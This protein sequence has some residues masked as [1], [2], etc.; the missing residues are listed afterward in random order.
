MQRRGWLGLGRR[1]FLKAQ[2]RVQELRGRA[3]A[4]RDARASMLPLDRVHR[5]LELL[6]AAI[7]G[8]SIPI[9][10]LEHKWTGPNGREF[11]RRVFRM[12]API[13]SVDGDAIYLPR[14]LA[15]QDDVAALTRY[16]L[17]ALEQ[18]E[19][20]IRGTTE[21]T[22]PTDQLERD[23]YLLR[24]GAAIDAHIA[25]HHHGV[26]ELLHSE[27]GKALARR[28][29][30]SGMTIAE[31]DVEGRL[32]E[33]LAE[34]PEDL[35]SPSP[36]P[37]ASLEWARD[38][39][40]SIRS[41]GAKYRGLPLT[42]I[43]GTVKQ[44]AATPIISSDEA[45]KDSSAIRPRVGSPESLV[46]SARSGESPEESKQ[47]SSGSGQ[48]SAPAEDSRGKQDDKESR[49]ES[50]R[51]PKDAGAADNQAQGGSP[52]DARTM[53]GSPMEHLPP[54]IYYD[55]WDSDRCVYVHRH[56]AV[57]LYQCGDA[58]E[59]WIRGTLQQ[60]AGTSRR[61]R[62]QFERLRARRALL[63]RQRAGDE[64][65][66]A[67]CV[68]AIVD[69]RLGHSGDDRLYIDARPARRGLAIALLVD[70]SGSTGVRVT[71]AMRIIDLERIAL[72][73]ASEALDALGD[74]YAV[75]SFCGREASNIK[76]SVIKDFA[77]QNGDVV[78]RRIAAMEPEGFTRLGAAIRHAT[79]QLARQSAGH[80]LLLILSDGRPNDVDSYQGSYGVEDS[81]QAVLEARASGVY[82]FCL[83][84]DAEASE[85][86]PRIFGAAGHTI[87]QR[88]EHLPKALL[89]VVRGLIGRA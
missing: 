61:I 83:T 64:L 68:N 4:R 51:D 76:L 25:Q 50:P 56:A 5:R 31:R 36:N 34:R 33:M 49:S 14:A 35:A 77:E 89:G 13:A 86:L 29:K 41:L 2:Y 43:W 72:L 11:A 85:Y 75:Y 16:R 44:R 28:P 27:R 39:A 67:A 52:S 71:E 30:L 17:I 53:V 19:R 47:Q 24:E 15:E 63:R 55:E 26:A 48:D 46:S 59:S 23:L 22:L 8:R 6:L 88:P 84:I 7:Y 62:H 21:Q 45:Q 78:Q 60:H 80:R 37:A 74:L 12:G 81:R 82:P 20:M 1:L 9:A 54:P 38:T 70:V 3:R 32:R 66:I 73:L 40:R 79:V 69:R 18:A 58:D 42:P 10:P 87:L 65:D 57:R